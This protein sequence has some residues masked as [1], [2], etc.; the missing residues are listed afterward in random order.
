MDFRATEIPDPKLLIA[1]PFPQQFGLEQ[2]AG[3]SW[4]ESAVIDVHV[5]V[6][7][8]DCQ[9]GV[10]IFDRRVEDHWTFFSIN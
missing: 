6:G 5:L 4:N 1:H 9:Q 10:V 2:M 3:S 8:I 7:Q